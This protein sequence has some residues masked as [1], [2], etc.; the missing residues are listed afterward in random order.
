VRDNLDDR[1]H[2]RHTHCREWSDLLG[3]LGQLKGP[4]QQNRP[5]QKTAD[6]AIIVMRRRHVGRL[7]TPALERGIVIPVVIVTSEIVARCHSAGMSWPGFRKRMHVNVRQIAGH[8]R[9]QVRRG[10]QQRGRSFDVAAEHE[11]IR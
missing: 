3:N 2:G 6:V 9:Q 11:R 7:V 1:L 8:E 10:G 5:A 4:Y